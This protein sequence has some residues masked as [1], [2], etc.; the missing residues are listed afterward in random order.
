[1]NF[2]RDMGG[3]LIAAIFLSMLILGGCTSSRNAVV[4]GSGPTC[5]EALST[6]LQG[7]SDG[8]VA[9][10]LDNALAEGRVPECW[11]PG[12]EF[13]LNENRDIPHRHLAEAV[14]VFNRR[15]YEPLFHKAVYRYLAE[16]EKG[17]APYRPEDRLL[18]ESYCRVIINRAHSLRDKNLGQAQL[19]CRRLDEG[20]YERFFGSGP[21][22]SQ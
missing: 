8:E 10:I 16:I 7:Y 15:R 1:M 6:G 17:N 19:L 3:R 9:G 12:M 13:C 18:L 22:S 5:E 20:L 11:M 14:K 2:L 21:H 4:I